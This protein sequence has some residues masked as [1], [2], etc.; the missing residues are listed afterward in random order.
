MSVSASW[1]GFRKAGDFIK[2]GL[3]A[4]P[5]LTFNSACQLAQAGEASEKQV[6]T[7]G[8]SCHSDANVHYISHPRR[9]VFDQVSGKQHPR[10]KSS[11]ASTSTCGKCGRQHQKSKCPVEKWK[12]FSCGKYGHVK[13]LCKAKGNAA[14][15]DEQT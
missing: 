2:K 13:K 3:L 10:K 9:K 4:E 14:A 7:L 5:K 11:V 12:C 8:D 6:M 15:V 1:R